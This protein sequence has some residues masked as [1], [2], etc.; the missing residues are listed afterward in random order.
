MALAG[1]ITPASAEGGNDDDD[2]QKKR[3]AKRS[4]Q[5]DSKQPR[6]RNAVLKITDKTFLF[7]AFLTI[8]ACTLW[9]KMSRLSAK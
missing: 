9:N 6:E 8:S 1:K 5:E 3:A 4:S 2:D 7:F